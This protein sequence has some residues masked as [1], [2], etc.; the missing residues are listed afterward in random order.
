MLSD[1]ICTRKGT[2]CFLLQLLLKDLMKDTGTP[3]KEKKLLEVGSSPEGKP[4]PHASHSPGVWPCSRRP[5]SIL[6]RNC[7]PIQGLRKKTTEEHT[8]KRSQASPRV[9][10]QI[11]TWC[12][13]LPWYSPTL[14][15]WSHGDFPCK[16]IIPHWSLACPGLFNDY[17]YY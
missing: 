2:L 8:L 10:L 5:H 16:N 1:G 14:G 11:V 15:Q 12:F 3:Q 9:L 17:I 6:S 13:S 4:I 7:F